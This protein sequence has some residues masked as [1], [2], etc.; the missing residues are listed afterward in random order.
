MDCVTILQVHAFDLCDAT[1]LT[2]NASLVLI[3]WRRPND[4]D[5]THVNLEILGLA[6][7]ESV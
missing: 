3:H 6:A 7:L 5:R 1:R 2:C 4:S